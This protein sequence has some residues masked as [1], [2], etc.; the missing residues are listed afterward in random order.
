M[1]TQPEN[2]DDLIYFTRRALNDGEGK[3][4]AW[5]YKGV[6]S[7]CGKGKMGK[8]KD[9]KTGKVKIRSKE[10]VCP[11]CGNVEEK[12]AHEETLMCEISYTCPHCKK[13]GEATVPFQRKSVSVF[14]EEKQKKVSVKA[15]KAKCEHCD[16][17]I[18][19]VKKMKK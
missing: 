4:M 5:V 10:Y 15:V 14:D 9:P 7:K 18:N 16:G 2:M 17:A 12:V 19:I 6:C 13:E 3:C 8:P 11:E 1:V